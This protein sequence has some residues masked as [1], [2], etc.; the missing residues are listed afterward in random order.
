MNNSKRMLATLTLAA[1]AA[2]VAAAVPAH[3]TATASDE[4][5]RSVG[6]TVGESLADPAET[7]KQVLEGGKTALTV[8]DAALR[9]V[10]TSSQSF[11][12]S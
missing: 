9:S 6:R 12:P 10:K 3:A 8:T 7:G 5:H 1:A 4:G 2:S 11:S